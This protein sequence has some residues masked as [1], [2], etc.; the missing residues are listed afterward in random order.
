MKFIR[1]FFVAAIA[2]FSLEFST[3]SAAPVLAAAPVTFSNTS[4]SAQAAP[5]H[6]R[7]IRRHRRRI[8]H[9][10]HR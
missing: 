7:H 1:F 5:Q 3:A 2:V 4:K 6:N 9:Q 10:H 8:H